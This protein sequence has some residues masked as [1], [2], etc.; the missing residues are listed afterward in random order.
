MQHAIRAFHGDG[1]GVGIARIGPRPLGLL[2]DHEGTIPAAGHGLWGNRGV[3]GGGNECLDIAADRL[4]FLQIT[5]PVQVQVARRI[6][7]IAQA[8]I[9]VIQINLDIR[10]P[11]KAR[12]HILDAHRL[13]HGEGGGGKPFVLVAGEMIKPLEQDALCAE[14]VVTLHLKVIEGVDAQHQVVEDGVI[15]AQKGVEQADV[16]KVHNP[17]LILVTRVGVPGGVHIIRGDDMQER[18]FDV[19]IQRNCTALCQHE[20]HG[21]ATYGIYRFHASSLPCSQ[22]THAIYNLIPQGLVPCQG[23]IQCIHPAH[24]P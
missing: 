24:T 4:V 22:H 7:Q 12:H 16:G 17:V 20:V 3:Q 1:E 19:G 14:G 18:L 8:Q 21:H 11:S 6:Q 23:N 13:V 9:I 15:L 2:R 10:L 5:V